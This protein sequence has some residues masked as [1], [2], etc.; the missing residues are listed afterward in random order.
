MVTKFLKRLIIF[1]FIILIS[2]LVVINMTYGA[3]KL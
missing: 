3:L 2:L 1:I